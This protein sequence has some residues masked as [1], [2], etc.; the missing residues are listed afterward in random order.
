MAAL[1]HNNIDLLLLDWIRFPSAHFGMK[2]QLQNHYLP[3]EDIRNQGFNQPRVQCLYV[4][5]DRERC[6]VGEE[7][8]LPCFDPQPILSVGEESSINDYIMHL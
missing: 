8:Y 4:L 6:K 5:Q 2:S 1:N 7:D 3:D